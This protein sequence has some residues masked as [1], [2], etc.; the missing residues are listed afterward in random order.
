MGKHPGGFD[1]I[2]KN[3]GGV[4]AANRPGFVAWYGVGEERYA[5][6]MQGITTQCAGETLDENPCCFDHIAKDQRRVAS[7]NLSNLIRRN[8]RW[9][10]TNGDGVR[11]ITTV[12]A[13][14]ILGKKPGR[15]DKIPEYKSG[16]SRAYC[17]GFLAGRNGWEKVYRDGMRGV[18]AQEIL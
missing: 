13:W 3:Q 11:G 1:K 16:V 5:D 7:A 10:E 8:R 4:T 15:F 2:A 12:G 14:I 17:P 9:K 6:S 18:A